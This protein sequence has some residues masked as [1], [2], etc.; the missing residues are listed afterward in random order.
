MT[1]EEVCVCVHALKGRTTNQSLLWMPQPLAI[2]CTE[3][4]GIGKRL[5][6]LQTSAG[7]VDLI[8]DRF[9]FLC[10]SNFFWVGGWVGGGALSWNSPPFKRNPAPP[11]LNYTD[12]YILI[13]NVF[14]KLRSTRLF[15]TIISIIRTKKKIKT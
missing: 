13:I 3:N 10:I 11:P 9:N 8:L 4:K 15:F 14:I 1:T 12:A 7:Q 6:E 5:C 2:I